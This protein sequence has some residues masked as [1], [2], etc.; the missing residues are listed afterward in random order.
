MLKNGE[1]DAYKY[2]FKHHYPYLCHVASQYLHDDYLAET[3]VGDVIFH[4]WQTRDTLEIHSSLRSYLVR[5]V[6]NK[7]IDSMKYRHESLSIEAANANDAHDL[8]HSLT[9]ESGTPLGQLIEKEL[10]EDIM[11]AV[12]SLPEEC[13][14][15]FIMNRFEGKK[16]REIATELGISINTVKYHI[17]RALDF[18]ENRLG[19]YILFMTMFLI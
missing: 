12:N 2:L 19:K 6:C 18:L 4:L 17:K 14:R 10:E 8:I 3:V 5:S 13:R 1:D 15:V 7:C 11:R 16:Y 9:D